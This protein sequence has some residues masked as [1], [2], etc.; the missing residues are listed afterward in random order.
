LADL[1][2]GL[3]IQ[4][5]D[6][7]VEYGAVDIGAKTYFCPVRSVSLSRGRTVNAF[8]D[9]VINSRT[10]GPSTTMLNDVVFAEYHVFRAEMR[11]ISGDDSERQ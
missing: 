5:A 9:E 6:V 10:W 1:D 7:M 8:Q 11:V 4:R 2:P 3:P